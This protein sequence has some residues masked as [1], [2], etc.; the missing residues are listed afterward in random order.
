MF[1]YHVPAVAGKTRP[2]RA[3]LEALGLGY[4]LPADGDVDALQVGEGPDKQAGTLLSPSGIDG[5]CR[6]VPAEQTWVRGPAGKYWIGY[7]NN[8]KP[9][10]QWLRRPKLI[11]GWPVTLLDGD[12]WTV[13]VA[14]S[15]VNGATL[16]Q[17]LML[18]EDGETW[19]LK[20]LP[21]Y[22]SLCKDADFVFDLL[23]TRAQAGEKV[24]IAYADGMRI[25]VGALAV[26]Y[27]ISAFEASAIE[28]FTGDA[29]SEVLSALID[30]PGL[31]KMLD[32]QAK[33]ESATG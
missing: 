16:P 24:S 1:L 4:I 10:E 25:A 6:Y 28:L 21:Q 30:M 2:S 31:H 22:F 26:N 32:A 17:R 33:K 15:L 3:D 13:P 27:R 7:W 12:A 18:G 9:T 8:H 20:D 11:A 23:V 29:M 14:R 5:H 19:L